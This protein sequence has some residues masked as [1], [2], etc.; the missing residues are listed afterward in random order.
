M[1]VL[2]SLFYH[3]KSCKV[4]KAIAPE[5][6]QKKEKDADSVICLDSSEDEDDKPLSKLR[7]A[8]NG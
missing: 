7:E 6:T 5:S 8:E 3:R 2:E 1:I 4:I